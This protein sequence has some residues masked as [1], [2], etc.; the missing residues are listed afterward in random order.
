MFY[1]FIPHIYIIFVHL[2]I[3]T[4]TKRRLQGFEPAARLGVRAGVLGVPSDAG[5][6][7]GLEPEVELHGMAIDW[8]IYF[9]MGYNYGNYNY[10]LLYSYPGIPM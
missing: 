10:G 3:T 1:W 6:N 5:P 7:A 9:T 4:A 8:R 2:N